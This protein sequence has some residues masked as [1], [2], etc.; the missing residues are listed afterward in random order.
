MAGRDFLD[1]DTTSSS[2][3]AIVNKTFARKF[4]AR[5]NPV[6]STFG[7]IQGGGKPDEL[8]EVIGLV[9]DTKYNDLRKEFLGGILGCESLHIPV[10]L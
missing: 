9:K 6:G 5:P 7:V 1:T 2:R 10:L 4:F 3:V 8:Y